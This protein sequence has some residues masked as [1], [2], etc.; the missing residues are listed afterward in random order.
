MTSP[1]RSGFTLVEALVS[2][3]LV[4]VGLAVLFQ[5][6]TGAARL[7]RAASETAALTLLA[8]A[9]LAVASET[10]TGPANE[11]GEELGLTWRLDAVEQ[12]RSEEALLLSITATAAAPDGASVTLRSALV[13]DP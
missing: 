12:A 4:A 13:V 2:L 5:L 7:H 6:T 9:R 3:S 11:S 8:E 1:E 10:L